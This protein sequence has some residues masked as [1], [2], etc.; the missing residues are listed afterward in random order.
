M[1]VKAIVELNRVDMGC[2]PDRLPS[3]EITLLVVTGILFIAIGVSM[4]LVFRRWKEV[5]FWLYKHF[6]I[7]DKSDIGED[8]EGIK[9]DGLLS[10]R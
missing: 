8:L 2:Y 7:L 9:F 10:Y 5:K 1:K 3:W 6:D 4:F